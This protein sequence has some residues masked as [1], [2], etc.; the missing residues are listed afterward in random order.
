MEEENFSVPGMNP[1]TNTRYDSSTNSHEDEEKQMYVVFS[2]DQSYPQ[3]LITFT[4][5]I[6][7]E[8]Y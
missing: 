8:E 3:W 2:N 7:F 1:E 4:M 5:D 6:I